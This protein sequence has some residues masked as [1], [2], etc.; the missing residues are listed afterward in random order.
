MEGRQVGV[1]VRRNENDGSFDRDGVA[2]AVRAVAVEEESR[3]IFVANAKKMQ[4]IVADSE[5]HERCI[6][7][8]I[9]RM[10]SYKE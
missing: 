4:E 1:Q 10:T 6:D 9:Q 5:V 8:F 2:A 7:G 3:M